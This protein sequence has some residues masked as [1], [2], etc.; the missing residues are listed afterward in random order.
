MPLIEDEPPSTLPPRPE[1][2]AIAGAGIGLGLVA[3][4]DRRVGKGLAK[5]ERDVDPA[6]ALLAAG[7]EQ[8]HARR[9]V[10]AEPR[11]DRAPGRACADDDKIGLNDIISSGHLSAPLPAQQTLPG[12]RDLHHRGHGGVMLVRN[13][14]AL[15]SLW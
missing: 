4:I 15:R 1:H 12:I 7:L 8:E 14:G 11:R 10:F 6:V 13:L 5:A 3:P 9:R 2:A